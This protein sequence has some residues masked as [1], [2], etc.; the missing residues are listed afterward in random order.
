MSFDYRAYLKNNFLLQE[1]EKEL[2]KGKWVD[3]D[4]QS[5]EEYKQQI[6]N[7]IDQ[8]YAY[9]G[10]HSN[11]KSAADVTGAEGDADYEVI[12]LDNDPEID[13]VSVSKKGPG[14]TKFTA[15]G[16]DGSSDAKSK[17]V[18]HKADLLKQSG[19]YIEVSGKI[20]DVLVAKGA[21]IVKDPEVI[22]KALAGKEIEKFNDDGSYVRKIAGHPH[23]K[24][25]LG[26]PT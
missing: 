17:V 20:K 11:Y 21:P 6:F 12:D 1:E 26:N 8:A 23:E 15:T 7:L 18:N 9:I 16:H 2:P 5:R 25:M 4:S 22:K 19:F 14:G 24:V 3:L 13:A 10:G